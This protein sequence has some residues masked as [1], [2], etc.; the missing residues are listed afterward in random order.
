M[1]ISELD[2]AKFWTNIKKTRY[3]WLWIAGKKE[4]G[5]GIYYFNKKS[6]QAHRLS[7]EIVYGKIPKNKCIC[8]HCDN[9]SCVN[10]DHLFVGTHMENML[11][12]Q[13]KSCNRKLGR[14]SIYHGVCYRF[15][16]KRIKRWRAQ[17]K[18]RGKSISVGT[19]KKEIDAALAYDKK[20]YELFKRKEMLNFPNRIKYPD[21]K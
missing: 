1:K 3:C 7:Y 16:D 21:D 14:S 15:D 2:K 20:C 13:I 4:R 19:Y 18:F 17:L 9:P 12:T 11:D 5:Y 6:Y 10:P 8:H